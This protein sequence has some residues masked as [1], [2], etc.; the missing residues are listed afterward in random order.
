MKANTLIWIVLVLFGATVFP[1]PAQPSPADRKQLDQ[2][3]AA[4]E[5]GDAE[6]QIELA[7]IYAAGDG[8]PRDVIKAAKWHRKAAE[9]GN[10]RAQCLLGLDYASGDGVKKS[11]SEAVY[12]LGKAADQGLAEAQYDLGMCFTSG[13]V[14]GKSIVDAAGLF[15]KAAEQGLAQA[16]A[17]LGSCYFD[18]T[19]VPKSIPDGLLWTR[20]AAEK[21]WPGAQQTLGLCYSKGKGV[22]TNFVQAYKWL[23]LAAAKDNQNSDEIKV[24]LSS[25]E[26]FMTPEQIAE[27]QKLAQEFVPGATAA[28]G[29]NAPVAA[30][31]ARTGSVNV[32]ADDDTY[33]IFVDG[34][35]VGNTPAKLKLAEG[36]HAVEVKKPGFKDYRKQLQ[37]SEGSELT[38]R[39][40]LEKQ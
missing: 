18:G 10:A 3:K 5:K 2:I 11:V 39:A 16:E 37:V 19:G 21:G 38:L 20:R 1:L 14:R 36:P 25:V 23:A 31:S 26:R 8:V 35:F 12:W 22:E 13:D 29:T 34:A 24:N 17:M 30:A 32:K 15:R 6:A 27:A 9:Q 28:G 4:A 33:E 7:A 40:V